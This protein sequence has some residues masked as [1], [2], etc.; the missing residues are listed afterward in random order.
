M[1]VRLGSDLLR[2]FVDADGDFS[3]IAMIDSN[4]ST[5]IVELVCEMIVMQ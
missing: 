2:S 1:H 5:Q 4:D 3:V